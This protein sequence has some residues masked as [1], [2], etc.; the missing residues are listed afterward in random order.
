MAKKPESKLQLKIRK[1]LENE[2]GGYWRK[3]HGGP[4][5]AAGML[6]LLGCVNGYFIAIEVKRDEDRIGTSKLQNDNI[7][8]I[9]EAGGYATVSSSPE[10]AVRKVKK[11]LRSK[12]SSIASRG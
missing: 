3:I 12:R 4:F 8:E 1:A 5:Q 9:R 7:T 10:A 6:D 11:W 2:V